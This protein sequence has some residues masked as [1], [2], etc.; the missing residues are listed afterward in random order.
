[1]PT[2]IRVRFAATIAIIA[3]LT[4]ARC[5]RAT[6]E[7]PPALVTSAAIPPTLFLKSA[8][9]G[10]AELKSAKATAKAGDTITIR[11]RIGG[12]KDPFVAGRAIFT[13]ADVSLPTCNARAD[14]ACP[15]PWDY[16]CEAPDDLRRAVATVQVV[17]AAG[18]ALKASLQGVGDLKP[19]AEV[20]VEGRVSAVD[21][22]GTLVIDATGLFVKPH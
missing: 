22:S 3:V 2:L 16:C 5:N 14:D 11:G 8:P 7:T 1:M 13:I 9:A 10:A 15:T 17:D 12:R 4:G 6:D 18:H 20:F 21:E 19:L